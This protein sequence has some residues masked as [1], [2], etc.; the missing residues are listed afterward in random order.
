MCRAQP[1]IESIMWRKGPLPAVE[2][3]HSRISTGEAITTEDG[4][5]IEQQLLVR[6]TVPRDVMSDSNLPTAVMLMPFSDDPGRPDGAHAAIA[7]GIQGRLVEVCSPGVDYWGDD[8]ERAASRL[9]PQQADYLRRGSFRG[10]G[11]AVATVVD[12]VAPGK[13]L[14][15]GSSMAAGSVAALATALTKRD[16]EIAGV[17]FLE[18]ANIEKRQLGALAIA[19]MQENGTAPLYIAT[20][21][22]E[23]HITEGFGSWVRRVLKDAPSN[24]AYARALAGGGFFADIPRSVVGTLKELEVPVRIERAGA[25]RILSEEAFAAQQRHFGELES[26]DLLDIVTYGDPIHNPHGHGIQMAPQ[27]PVD[28]INTLLSR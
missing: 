19:F 28:S 12:K 13:N 24:A 5:E 26:V 10:I 6:Q 11:E 2:V 15:Y 22:E 27:V 8:E 18:T 4:R 25:S 7:A 1:N 16:R 14:L 23:L 3:T 9:T 21:P 17:V 20:R